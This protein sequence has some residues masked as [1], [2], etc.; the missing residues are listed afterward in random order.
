MNKREAVQRFIAEVLPEIDVQYG[1]DDIPA[2]CEA[3]N[4]WTDALCKEG[5]ITVKQ[6]NEWANPF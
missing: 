1:E 6:Y 4:N 3:W 5:Q 2:R